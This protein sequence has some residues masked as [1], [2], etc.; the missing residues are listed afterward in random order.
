[1]TSVISL[2]KTFRKQ[3]QSD[4]DITLRVEIV[5]VTCSSTGK[6]NNFSET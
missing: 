3:L 2:T 5:K 4:N 1:M 6:T